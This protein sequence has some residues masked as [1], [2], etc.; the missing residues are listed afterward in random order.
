[1]ATS[2]THS[3]RRSQ[4][5]VR[6]LSLSRAARAARFMRVQDHHAVGERRLFLAAQCLGCGGDSQQA[7]ATVEQ[8]SPLLQVEG[9][10]ELKKVDARFGRGYS[11]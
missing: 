8:T 1:M 4:I 5:H 10:S 3:S 6:T 9:A 2:S 11:G 7:V